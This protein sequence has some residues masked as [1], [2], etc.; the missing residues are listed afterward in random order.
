MKDPRNNTFKIILIVMGLM[1]LVPSL[2]A[3]NPWKARFNVINQTGKDIYFI[4]YPQ[5]DEGEAYPQLIAKSVPI[6]PEDEE[7]QM[8]IDDYKEAVTSKFTITRGIYDVEVHAC[9][10]IAEGQIDLTRN[11]RLNFTRCEL[12]P[13][14]DTKKYHGEPSMEKPNWFDAPGLTLFRF[15]YDVPPEK[16]WDY[17][18][19]YPMD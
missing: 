16:N 5:D 13:N 11:L 14:Y 19:F 3:V 2:L 4:M 8:E 18:E 1:L 15:K 7:A 12:M 6:D 17:E 10:F 9:G